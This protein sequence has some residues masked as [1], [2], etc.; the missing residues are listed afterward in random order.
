MALVALVIGGAAL[1]AGLSGLRTPVSR[2]V[3]AATL[4]SALLFVQG[5]PLAALLHLAPLDL[6]DWALAALGGC[7]AALPVIGFRLGRGGGRDQRPRAAINASA[8]STKPAP[9]RDGVT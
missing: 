3:S 5:P 4:A 9:P 2:V 8:S 6:D 1:S 7:G